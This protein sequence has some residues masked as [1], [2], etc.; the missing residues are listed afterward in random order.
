MNRPSN[1]TIALATI[2]FLT[3]AGICDA[4]APQEGRHG[5]VTVLHNLHYRAADDKACTLDLAM[6]GGAKKKP[7]PAIVVIH[8][9]GWIEGDKS[10]FASDEH[11]VPGNIVEFARLGF[12]A[13]TINYRLAGEATYPAAIVDCQCAVRFLRAHADEYGI[14]PDRI[15]AYG[16]SA[17]G[18]L[19]L[20]LAMADRPAE[21]SSKEPFAGQSSAVQAAASDSG[22]ID[23]VR[24]HEQN[25]LRTVIERF[26]GG[27]PAAERLAAYREAS[28]SA[29][30]ATKLPPLLLIYGETDEQVDVRTADDFVAALGRAGCK[31][32]SYIRLATIGHCPHSLKRVPYLKAV[33]NDFF[34]R[35]LRLAEGSDPGS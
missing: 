1:D 23:L 4:A 14:D 3:G 32:V 17:G 18:H 2:L 8:G 15:G 33:V 13:A 26:L 22:P 24:Q 29:H 6:P 25:Q 30:V 19:A 7:R 11:G 20:L 34:A 28:P 16:N 5:D 9:G 31:D 35:R 27:P 12:V 21:N 10:S